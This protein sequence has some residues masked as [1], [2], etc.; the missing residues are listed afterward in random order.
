M[1]TPERKRVKRG[2]PDRSLKPKTI[3]RIRETILTLLATAVAFW[4]LWTYTGRIG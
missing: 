1:S 3:K 2:I 4:L